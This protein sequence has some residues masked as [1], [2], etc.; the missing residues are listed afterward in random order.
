MHYSENEEAIKEC[1]DR[2]AIRD[3][4]FRYSRAI[5]RVDRAL[6]KTVYWPDTIDEKEGGIRR[7]VD[8][9]ADGL[10]PCLSKRFRRSIT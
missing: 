5:D 6:L 9:F 8:E 1:I 7:T 2:A 4:L 3:V 10:S